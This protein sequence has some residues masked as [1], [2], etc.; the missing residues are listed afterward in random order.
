[1]FTFSILA[2]L[3]TIFTIYINYELKLYESF[4]QISKRDL[5]IMSLT[6]PIWIP[7]LII[8][9]GIIFLLLF[10]VI[11]LIIISGFIIMIVRP[12]A[13]LFEIFNNRF[14]KN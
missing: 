4:S 14:K 3:Y 8:V 6:W 7:F 9:F 13:F 11:V 5:M 10:S 12:F 1:M 2:I